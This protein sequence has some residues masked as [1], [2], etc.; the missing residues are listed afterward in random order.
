M[1]ED[2]ISPSRSRRP[3]VIALPEPMETPTPELEELGKVLAQRKPLVA[4]TGAGISVESGIPDFRSPDGIWTRYPIEEYGTIHA[5][6][7][8]PRK[9]WRMLWELDE[10]LTRA[11][12]NPAHR[13]LA[14][15]ERLGLLAAVVT[16]N[17]DGLHQAAGSR[18][19][20]EFH[21]SGRHLVCL[22]CGARYGAEEISGAPPDPP[23]CQAC[24]AVLKPDVILF[25]EPI[26]EGALY[27]AFHY[28]RYCGAMLVVGTSAQVAPASQLPLMARQ[29]GALVVE[30]NLAETS[31]TPHADYSIRG[32]SSH[33]LPLLV[34]AIRR[35]LNLHAED[36]S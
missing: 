32:R 25:G 16:Q 11:E 21:G 7:H 26:P 15:L 4:L 8:N 20:V 22:E 36:G 6:R 24:G 34:R 29:F 33:T 10:L 28:T 17:V 19:V 35:H 14:E 23:V 27:A 9:V 1:S 5:F 31:L 2:R 18:H 13:A 12:P 30:V 3:R